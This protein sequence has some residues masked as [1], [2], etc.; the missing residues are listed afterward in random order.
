MTK[1]WLIRPFAPKDLQRLHVVR[2]AAFQPVFHSFR[3][4][5]GEA[6]APAAFAKAEEEQAQYLDD[7]CKEGSAFETFVVE[8]DSE[9]AAFC[10]ISF[11][12][13]QKLGEINL[14]ATHP[15]YQG[16]GIAAL[17]FEHALNRMR[18]EGMTV[19]T[20]ATGGDPSHEP[21]RAAYEKAGFSKSIPSVYMYRTL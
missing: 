14:T 10:A 1:D 3:T 11:D 17:M 9:V 5:V 21:A 15:D 6:I 20:V 8:A 12:N 13:T 7:I 18:E 19:A 2:V 16:R 4:I